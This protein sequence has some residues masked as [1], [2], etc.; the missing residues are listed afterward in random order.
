MT[1]S[2]IKQLKHKIEHD[3][4]DHT[5]DGR[6]IRCGMCCPDILPVTKN[7]LITIKRY[8]TRCNVIPIRQVEC[9]KAGRPTD[10]RLQCPFSDEKKRKCLIYSVRPEI[11]RLFIC[12]QPPD[13]IVRNQIDCSINKK[14]SLFVSMHI[15]FLNDE[16]YMQTYSSHPTWKNHAVTF[17]KFD[18]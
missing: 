9:D 1:E 2:T 15:A 7:E 5:K 6:C 12:S 10:I 11:C 18:I 4:V 14:D 3:V 17:V 8:I 13:V 16:L